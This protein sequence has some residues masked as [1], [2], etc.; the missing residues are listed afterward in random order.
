MYKNE[1]LSIWYFFLRKKYHTPSGTFSCW[2]FFLVFV[3]TK[4]VLVFFFSFLFNIHMIPD[5]IEPRAEN[6]I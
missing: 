5:T 1:K 2:Y 6:K 3:M 4:G